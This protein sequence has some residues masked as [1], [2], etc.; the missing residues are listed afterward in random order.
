MGIGIDICKISRFSKLFAKGVSWQERFAKRIL[1]KTEL[2]EWSLILNEQKENYNSTAT[3]KWFATRW[4][5]KEAA[6]K[7]VQPEHKVYM[8]E[9]MLKHSSNGQPVL[10]ID[11]KGENPLSVPVSLSH[12]DDYVV[13]VAIYMPCV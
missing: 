12:E 11:R 7:A 10:F 13:A 3:A 6:F 4:S 5:T 9:M 8:N 2:L 1:H